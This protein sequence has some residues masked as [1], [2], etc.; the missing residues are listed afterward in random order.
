[1]KLKSPIK[2]DFLFVTFGLGALTF[3]GIALVR[4]APPRKPYV[5]LKP[6]HPNAKPASKTPPLSAA[7]KNA[8]V[9]V[10]DFINQ[11]CLDCHSTE[12]QKGDLNL[13]ALKFD[14]ADPR[15]FA[16]LSK[17]HDR[18]RDGEM[19]PPKAE[20]PTV[21]ERMAFKNAL[22]QQLISAENAQLAPTGRTVLRRL[23]R[24]QYENTVRDLL[25]APWLQLKEMLPEDGQ[26]SRFNT[27]GEALDV[28][29]VQMSRY[30]QA[31]DYALN[32][33]MV[34]AV[35][36]PATTIKRY[37]TRDEGSFSGAY[38]VGPDVR[39]TFPVLGSGPDQ[40]HRRPPL[41][42]GDSNPKQRDEEGVGVVLSTY[43]PTEIRWSHFKA[44]VAGR[45]QL[46]F[47]TNTI[48]VGAKKAKDWWNQDYTNI[49]KGRRSEPITI[50]SDREPRLL[51]RLGSFDATPEAVPH[52]M[53]VWLLKGETIRPDAAR[54]LRPRPGAMRNPW[55]TPEGQP[56]V[57]FRWMEVVGPIYDEY[58]TAGHNLMFGAI[59]VESG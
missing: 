58:P 33:A 47:M 36:R 27:V 1:M 44:P 34:P 16:I 50:Y 41:T 2:P 59:A 35:E 45:Y 17:V 55:A 19:P 28:S 10:R 24:Y 18:V 22:A 20:Q 8:I 51:R 57:S 38:D 12:V 11:R 9:P 42:V 26:M 6:A 15:E 23:N 13:E 48:W 37:Y 14:F 54:F 46:R 49:T 7:Q 31:A 4:A 56:A 30:L 39:S 40:E 21:S 43:E 32:Q 3:T 53:D 52:S 29:H 5:P 25:S